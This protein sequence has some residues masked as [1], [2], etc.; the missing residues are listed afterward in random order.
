MGEPLLFEIDRKVATLFKMR[1]ALETAKRE[2]VGAIVPTGAGATLG[3]PEVA[4]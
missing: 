3:R 4:A 2:R 1:D